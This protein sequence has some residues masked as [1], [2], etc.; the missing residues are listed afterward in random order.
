[1]M[2]VGVSG[3]GLRIKV[4]GRALVLTTPL[5]TNKKGL[6]VEHRLRGE[7]ARDMI[8]LFDLGQENCAFDAWTRTNAAGAWE[9]LED[10]SWR[11]RPGD[12][13]S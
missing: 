11:R 4:R 3:L 7:F 9:K 2:V 6:A 13:D 8:R 5:L 1:M 10:Y 12:A